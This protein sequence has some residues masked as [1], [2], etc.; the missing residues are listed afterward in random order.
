MKTLDGG[1]SE[2]FMKYARNAVTLEC[3]GEKMRVRNENEG[4]S[5]QGERIEGEG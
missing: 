1:I 5:L 3:S 2:K 4:G